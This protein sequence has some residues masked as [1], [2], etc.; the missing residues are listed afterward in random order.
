MF[1]KDPGN[2]QEDSGECSKRFKEH[3]SKKGL[4]KKVGALNILINFFVS[5]I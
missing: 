5:L 3:C 1:K 2:V 4:L